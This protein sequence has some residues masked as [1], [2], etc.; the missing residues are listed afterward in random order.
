MASRK[1][2]TEKQRQHKSAHEKAVREQRK[3]EK[4]CISCGAQD[5]RTLDGKCLCAECREKRRESVRAAGGYKRYSNYDLCKQAKI[6]CDCKKQDAYTL[7]GHAYCYECNEIRNEKARQR[8]A[9]N[10]ERYVE[11]ERAH[12]RD[13]KEK[14]LCT[15]CGKPLD[16]PGVFCRRCNKKRNWKYARRRREAE[17]INW[18]RGSN[19]ICWQCNKEPVWNGKRLCK[20]CYDKANRILFEKAMPRLIELDVRSAHRPVIFPRDF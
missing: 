11:T 5:D 7:N 1:P 17:Q 19:G 12:Y 6:C 4:R 16:R 15:S 3:A 20:D 10:R 9:E 13:T 8:R 2:L 14:R 18:P